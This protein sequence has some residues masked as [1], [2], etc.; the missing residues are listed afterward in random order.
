MKRLAIVA[1]LGLAVGILMFPTT[2]ALATFGL[3]PGKVYIDNLHPGSEADLTITVYNQNDQ[4][5]A[6]TVQA[7]QPDY[8][9]KGYEE[10]T[11]LDWIT[12][13]PD[14]VTI[15]AH[16]KE[17]VQIVVVMPK[18]ADYSG[19]KAEVWISVKEKNASGM[20]QIELASRL[21]ISTRVE[22]ATQLTQT[23]AVSS[24]GSVNISADAQKGTSTPAG[25]V[26]TNTGGPKGDSGSSISPWAVVGIVVGAIVVG[27]GVFVLVRKR[28]RA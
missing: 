10:F 6:F 16:G 22:G 9:E 18:D 20:I 3:D 14:Q 7:R 1:F 5:T 4:Q 26:S 11:H 21:F 2:T 28:Q 23:P 27:G 13:T 12:A 24:T 15:G 19:K 8:T 17:K 25:T